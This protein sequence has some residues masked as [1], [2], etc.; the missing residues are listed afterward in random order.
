MRFGWRDQSAGERYFRNLPFTWRPLISL[1]TEPHFTERNKPGKC[2]Q[3][4]TDWHLMLWRP[5]RS[6]QDAARSPEATLWDQCH[7]QHVPGILSPPRHC[8]SYDEY[9]SLL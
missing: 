5:T 7:A 2:H 4:H 1:L 6:T 8:R 3:W 9:R